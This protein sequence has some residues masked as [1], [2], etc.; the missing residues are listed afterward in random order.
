MMS[1]EQAS[2]LASDVSLEVAHSPMTTR[3]RRAFGAVLAVSAVAFVASKRTARSSDVSSRLSVSDV[4]AALADDS[5]VTLVDSVC[6][7][8]D[9]DI[10]FPVKDQ[11]GAF[12]YIFICVLLR[13]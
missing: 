7:Q 11:C 9:D 5:V 4:S 1:T 6:N 13:G 10:F 12:C 2:L 8:Y 3:V